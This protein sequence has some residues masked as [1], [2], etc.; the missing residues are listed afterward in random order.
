MLMHAW[1]AGE[2]LSFASDALEVAHVRDLI[3]LQLDLLD[4][5]E[6]D[7]ALAE[8]LSLAADVGSPGVRAVAAAAL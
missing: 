2:V 5:P 4:H 7:S 6:R 1:V 3:A 8:R